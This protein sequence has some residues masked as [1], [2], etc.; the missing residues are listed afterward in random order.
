MNES[1]VMIVSGRAGYTL[2]MAYDNLHN[3]VSK[4]QH[5]TKSTVIS[6][7]DMSTQS[8]Y[9]KLHADWEKEFNQKMSILTNE[10]SEANNSISQKINYNF[11]QTSYFEDTNKVI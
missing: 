11:N 9:L 4:K 10:R 7:N 1:Q 5:L 2:E 6:F 8:K 3:I